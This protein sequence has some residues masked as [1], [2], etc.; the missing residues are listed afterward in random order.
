[1]IS[2]KRKTWLSQMRVLYTISI[3][4]NTVTSKRQLHSNNKC[5]C[6]WGGGGGGV[7]VYN[8]GLRLCHEVINKYKRLE[9]GH[10]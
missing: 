7:A 1:M 9:K 2:G 5:V 8:V 4:L 6:V 10:V 3:V